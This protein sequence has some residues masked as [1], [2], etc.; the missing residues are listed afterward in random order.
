MSTAGPKISA[1]E[2]LLVAADELFYAE[3]VHTV[4]IDR[5]IERAG[6]AKASLYSGFGSKDGLVTAYLEVRRDRLMARV[7]SAVAGA[8]GPR[9]QVLAIFDAMNKV[10]VDQVGTDSYR[11]CAFVAASAESPRGGVVE[12]V[13]DDYRAWLRG[14]FTDLTTQLAV[15]DPGLLAA[16][17]HLL[18]DGLAVGGRMDRTTVGGAA[19]RAAAETL[20]YAAEEK[21]TA[22]PPPPSN[23]L[24]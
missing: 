14:I 18:Y 1:R 24:P 12:R 5:V 6:V 10:L 13:S 17:L 7:E 21:T 20:I 23:A 8:K 19:A 3:G 9:A 4:G 11:G 2:R 15:P 16:Q 22:S